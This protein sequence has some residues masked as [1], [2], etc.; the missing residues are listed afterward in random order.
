M[1]ILVVDDEKDVQ[2]L[3]EQRFRK[4]IRN[5][6]MEFAFAYS[7]EDA[8]K[9]HAVSAI[10]SVVPAELNSDTPP[11]LPSLASARLGSHA[12]R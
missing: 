7:G 3:F 12:A 6:E 4:E 8:L 1:K 5:K 2:V 11:P 9:Y 10:R